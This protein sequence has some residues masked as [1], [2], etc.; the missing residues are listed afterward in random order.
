[1]KRTQHVEVSLR[2]FPF[3]SRINPSKWSRYNSHPA[4]AIPSLYLLKFRNQLCTVF[5]PLTV[6]DF[7][8]I[9]YQQLE[10]TSYEICEKRNYIHSFFFFLSRITMSLSLLPFS[11]ATLL[12]LY[13]N[14]RFCLLVL[15]LFHKLN[16]K[17]RKLYPTCFVRF[18]N[19]VCHHLRNLFF[20]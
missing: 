3:G 16:K 7:S 6:G 12:V 20:L 13:R 19:T 14:S 5:I 11:S 8:L 18:F 1:M 9:V 17:V 15:P 4:F 10:R 2:S